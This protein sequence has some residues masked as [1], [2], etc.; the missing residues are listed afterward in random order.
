MK[1][2]PRRRVAVVATEAALAEAVV[3][4]EAVP[5]EAVV[6]AAEAVAVAEVVAAVAAAVIVVGATVTAEIAG[7]SKAIR[8]RPICLFLKFKNSSWFLVRI[9]P[10]R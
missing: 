2:V 3:A 6:G 1:L 5:E 9:T 10:R 8:R 4:A 7:A